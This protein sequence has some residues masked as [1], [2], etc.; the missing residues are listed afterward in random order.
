MLPYYIHAGN[1]KTVFL[2]YEISVYRFAAH[3]YRYDF[4]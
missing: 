2:P 3:L 4:C 1:L